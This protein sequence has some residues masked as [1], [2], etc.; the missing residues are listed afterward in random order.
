MAILLPAINAAKEAARR[1]HCLNNVRNICVAVMNYESTHRYFPPGNIKWPQMKIYDNLARLGNPGDIANSFGM[2]AVGGWTWYLRIMPF[3]EETGISEELEAVKGNKAGV[4][5]NQP[6]Y[7]AGTCDSTVNV[8]ILN[9]RRFLWADCP[10]SPLPSVTP[11]DCS[12]TSFYDGDVDPPCFGAQSPI[13]RDNELFLEFQIADYAGISG[14]VDLL[15]DDSKELDRD[16]NPMNKSFA[17]LLVDMRCVRPSGIPCFQGMVWVRRK[18]VLDGF[19]KTMLVGEQSDECLDSE[20]L[21]Q[22]CRSTSG[23]MQTG[24]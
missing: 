20:G 10:S 21:P 17:G 15:D 22:D 13:V 9:N 2:N 23:R 4:G 6:V 11:R 7:R 16:D 18:H 24:T 1:T 8:Y 19:S 14:A 5:W 12:C 3:I